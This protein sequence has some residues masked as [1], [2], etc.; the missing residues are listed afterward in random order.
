[1]DRP[2]PFLRFARATEAVKNESPLA[3]KKR[4]PTAHE[5][6][7]DGKR[8]CKTP[9]VSTAVDTAA[10]DPKVD[11]RLAMLERMFAARKEIIAQVDIYGTH[12][13]FSSTMAPEHQ[14]WQIL[15]ASLLSTQ[16]K[17]A[18]TAA[19]MMRLH[20]LPGGLTIASVLALSSAELDRLLTP[21]GFHS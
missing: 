8:Q 16:T 3:P 5:E 7:R 15:V 19:A 17:D 10:A 4:Q 2:N 12:H 1:M 14:R 21:V 13:L 20:E 9:P 11:Q 18:I 6:P